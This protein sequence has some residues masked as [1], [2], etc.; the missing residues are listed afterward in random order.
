MRKINLDKP[1]RM[2]CSIQVKEYWAQAPP[3]EM[4]PLLKSV[5]TRSNNSLSNCGSFTISHRWIVGLVA[6]AMRA[7]TWNT[8]WNH[9][10]KTPV[11]LKVNN[12]NNNRTL[13]QQFSRQ[14]FNFSIN[15]FKQNRN[16]A[17][18]HF[19]FK[20]I[21]FQDWLSLCN[22]SCPG[23]LCVDKVA[24]LCL[25]CWLLRLKKWDTRSRFCDWF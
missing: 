12:S 24:C 8:L 17:N 9:V 21:Y 22:S 3:Q 2:S 5:P 6:F 1:A 13:T 25:P 11:I 19:K 23:I 16:I 14:M 15:Y 10:L 4:S 20:F 18:L 7:R